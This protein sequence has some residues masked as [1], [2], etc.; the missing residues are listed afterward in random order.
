MCKLISTTIAGML[1][2]MPVV[3]GAKEPPPTCDEILD[4]RAYLTRAQF[5]CGFKGY[6]Q[7]FLDRAAACLRTEG[8]ERLK[9]IGLKAINDFDADV[10]KYV[11]TFHS[12]RGYCA[13]STAS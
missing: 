5:Q 11:A 4:I 3:V 12:A 2:L 8:E 1:A 6:N 7:A 13:T 9:F 10:L